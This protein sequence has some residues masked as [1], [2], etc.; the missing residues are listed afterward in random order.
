MNGGDSSRK[1]L[2]CHIMVAAHGWLAE[3]PAPITLS[4][5]CYKRNRRHR[6]GD[7]ECQASS[8]IG[9]PRPPLYFVTSSVMTERKCVYDPLV[10]LMAYYADKKSTREEVDTSTLT[11]E[12][13]LKRRIIDGDQIGIDNDL[14]E[15]LKSYQALAIINDIL[16]DGMKVVGDLFGAGQ[17]QLPFVLQSAETMKRAVAYLEP[18]MDRAVDSSK[19]TMVLATVKGDVHDIGKNLVDIIL[20]NNGYNVVNLGIKV[21]VER[22][23]EAARDHKADAIGMSGL[24]VKSTLIMKENL[25]LMNGRGID[26]PVI[27]GGAALTRRYVEGDLRTIYGPNVAYAGDAFDGL[28]YMEQ[29]LSGRGVGGHDIDVAAGSAAP[30]DGEDI[31]IDEKA[32]RDAYANARPPAVERG[33][34][35]VRPA[36]EDE[37]DSLAELM[38]VMVEDLRS[39][40]LAELMVVELNEQVVGGG[41]ILPALEGS[42]ELTNIAMLPEQWKAGAGM[43]LVRGMRRAV[44]DINPEAPIYITCDPEDAELARFYRTLGFDQVPVDDPRAI[45]ANDKIDYCIE[46][47]G[48]A[49]ALFISKSA[50]QVSDSVGSSF[51]VS[52]H[53]QKE[54]SRD[55]DFPVNAENYQTD[56]GVH[57]LRVTSDVDRAVPVP[58]PPFYG[59]R[60]VENIHLDKVF[61]YVNEVALIRGQWQV[62]KGKR[63]AE[64]YRQELDRVVYPKLEELKLRAKRERLLEPKVIYGYFPCKADYNAL[65]IYKPKGMEGDGLTSEW[66]DVQIGEDGLEEW[67]RYEFPRQ[68]H[69]RHLCIADF[70]RPTE[71]PEFDVV[72]F[73]I[74]TMGRRAGE[75]SAELFAAN[76]YVDYLYFHGLSV[77]CAEALAEYWHKSVRIE[78]GT[79]AADAPEIRRLFSQGY[80]GS[81]YSFGYPACPNL[82]DQAKLFEMLRPERIGVTL[83]D[84]YMLDP[85]QSTSAV[86]VHHPAAKYFNIRE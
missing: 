45:I 1:R 23:L 67:M 79:A 70:F 16:L 17:M 40:G 76:N 71:T 72:A 36:A 42:Y 74:V 49:P 53:L 73:Q 64:E 52:M 56:H 43:E 58:R 30:G 8:Q 24:L 33:A 65:V 15:A 27:L 38:G 41:R 82:E 32:S 29:I 77:E 75:Y 12:E 22:M 68:S 59:S 11:V 21:P 34:V 83:S 55:A 28:H 39:A 19:G 46:T 35:R 20:T 63:S 5:T 62:K 37:L 10:E 69:G 44:R 18:F 2:A 47:Y 14:V 61:E 86:V 13:R 57:R 54:Q 26:V 48:K 4:A 80:Q 66:S 50:A 3:P 31:S 9:D 81:R 85:E 78:L 51:A 7:T 25:Q 84:E 6:V 60:V